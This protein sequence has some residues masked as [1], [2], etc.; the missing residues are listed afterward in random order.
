MGAAPAGLTVTLLR[1]SLSS[2]AQ[3]ALL[4]YELPAPL[5]RRPLMSWT[6]PLTACPWGPAELLSAPSPSTLPRPSDRKQAPELQQQGLAAALSSK[7]LQRAGLGL[8]DAAALEA[9]LDAAW[10]AAQEAES[11]ATLY[12]AT[13]GL[14]ASEA[15]VPMQSAAGLAEAG[16]SS[17]A[18]LAD[19]SPAGPKLPASTFDTSIVQATK[20]SNS[21][22]VPAEAPRQPAASASASA[23]ALSAIY[24][25]VNG[26][27]SSAAGSAAS[28]VNSTV[29]SIAGSAT[30]AV[31]ST[32]SAV[33]SSTAGVVNSSFTPL[34]AAASGSPIQSQQRQALTLD[35]SAPGSSDQAAILANP[36]QQKL[37]EAAASL[38]QEVQVSLQDIWV[39]ADTW[40]RSRGSLGQ[41]PFACRTQISS[42]KK[43]RPAP[44][45]SHTQRSLDW[46]C[47]LCKLLLCGVAAVVDHVQSRSCA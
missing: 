45:P 4:L 14:K 44:V 24:S 39:E 9:E 2:P 33:V 46:A 16:S 3:H 27:V 18:A 41:C 23:S 5:T 8:A 19:A 31:N 34:L 10:E 17:S 15:A 6:W 43:C 11:T 1:A 28:A 36:T 32:V 20:Q 42:G 47:R 38:L 30:N 22:A 26:T 25:A 37:R 13:S 29:S 21:S 7:P 35:G 40:L 12:P